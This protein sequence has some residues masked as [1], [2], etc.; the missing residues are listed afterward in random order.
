MAGVLALSFDENVKDYF[1]TLFFTSVGYT[2]C[3]RLL[4][5]GGKKDLWGMEFESLLYVPSKA[6]ALKHRRSMDR[7]PHIPPFSY[8][9]GSNQKGW[10]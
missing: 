1:M 3:F 2:A 6:W 4:K 8:E 7:Y 10:E 9:T 5:K